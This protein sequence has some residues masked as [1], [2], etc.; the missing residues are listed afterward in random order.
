MDQSE[1]QANY[2]Q[3]IRCFELYS[4]WKSLY[5]SCPKSKSTSIEFQSWQMEIQTA[6]KD[7]FVAITDLVQTTTFG[8]PLDHFVEPREYEIIRGMYVPK[9]VL[10]A[11]DINLQTHLYF[12]ENLDNCFELA[13]LIAND[14]NVNVY[15]PFM[16]AGK[17]GQL[18]QG[19]KDA[20]LASLAF[21]RTPWTSIND[22]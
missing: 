12:P 13:E 7:C 14:S 21:K 11:L 16:T 18:L 3:L 1:E 5:D 15:R 8:D 22:K 10:W 4:Q 2:Q 9:L 19:L 20:A 17:M 6:T